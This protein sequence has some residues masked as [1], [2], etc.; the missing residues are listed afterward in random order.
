MSK[1]K[2]IDSDNDGYENN[3]SRNTSTEVEEAN[4]LISQ[5]KIL[6]RELTELTNLN[7]L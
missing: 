3:H 7:F 1:Q 6:H 5:Q 4:K 2:W